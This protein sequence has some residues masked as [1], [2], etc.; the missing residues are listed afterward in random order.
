MPLGFEVRNGVE[1]LQVRSMCNLYSI[2]RNQAA[3]RDL[4]KV[5]K[6]TTGNLPPL[7]A[8][9]PDGIAPVVRVTED[10]RAVGGDLD[11]LLGTRRA[12]D[13]VE[14]GDPAD[15]AA[16]GDGPESG[17]IAQARRH[18]R[19][20]VDVRLRA[21]VSPPQRLGAAGMERHGD[22]DPHATA[23]EVVQR[24]QRRVVV[25]VHKRVDEQRLAVDGDRVARPSSAC[26]IRWIR[27]RTGCSTSPAS[28]RRPTCSKA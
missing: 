21:A 26:S 9:F 14:A 27:C 5:T 23:D 13:R 4:F 17:G 19:M 7:P 10:E 1:T 20:P 18:V 2:T 12:P 6:D 3:I 28:C 11:R 15:V 25:A 8:I 16:T 24:A 22:E